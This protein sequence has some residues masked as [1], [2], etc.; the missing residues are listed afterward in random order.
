MGKGARN[1]ANRRANQQS[2]NGGALTPEALDGLLELRSASDLTALLSRRPGL[3]ADAVLEQLREM[4]RAEGYGAT[5]DQL[6][7]LLAGAREDHLV[8]WQH[9]KRARDRVD[10]LAAELE[11]DFLAIEHATEARRDDDVIRLARAAIPKANAA[12]AGLAASELHAIV[13]KA[14]LRS[15]KAHR[16]E[17]LEEAITSFDAALALTVDPEQA[18]NHLMHLGLVYAERIR[19]DRADNL[20]RA[21]DLLRAA[22]DQLGPDTAPETWAIMRTNLAV[23]LQRTERGNRVEVLEEAE[24]LCREALEY[25]SP[26]VDAVDW[27][28]TQLNLGEILEEL[29]AIGRRNITD[30]TNAYSGIVD[31]A[32]RIDE[33]WLI[34][35]AHYALGRLQSRA[36]EASPEEILDAHERDELAQLFDTGDLLES[37][38]AHLA[39]ACELLA[40][41]PDPI[42]HARAMDQLGGVLAALE[43]DDDAIAISREALGILRPT[44]A[45]SACTNVGMRLGGLLAERGQWS[46]AAA[47]YRDAFQAAELTFH[48]R[49][50][51]DARER[52]ARRTR[53]LARWA[54]FVVARS[55]D[56]VEAARILESG[57]AREL[58]R[59][60]GQHGPDTERLA[61]LPRSLR[62]AYDDAV[63][64]LVASPMGTT[65]A[66][67]SRILQ[68]VIAEIRRIPGYEDFGAVTDL[69]D[70]AI[71][72]EPGWPVVYVNPTPFGTLLLRISGTL[73]E[74]V[75]DPIF[76]DS[77]RSID[78]FMRLMIGDAADHPDDA[79]S[80]SSYLIGAGGA[81]DR[82]NGDLQID[83]EQI[84]PW[85]G[86]AIAKPVHDCIAA[87]G[88][89]GAT[90]IP[91]GPIGVAPIHAAM[92]R[93]GADYRC[94]LDRFS[95][96]FAPSSVLASAS[97]RRAASSQT[98]TPSLVALGDPTGDLPAAEPEVREIMRHFEGR[99]AVTFGREANRAF[100]RAHAG[101]AT[102]LHLA[103]HAS[104]ALFDPD[105]AGVLLS[106][107]AVSAHDLTAVLELSTRLV[108]ISA[109]QTALSEIAG[110]PDEAFS[111]GTTMLAAGSAC[112]IA[113]LWPVHDMATALL[114]A[115]LYDE[116]IVRSQRPPE[117]L[118]RAQLWLRDLT[119]E[120]EARFLLQ[121]PALADEFRERRAQNRRLPPIRATELWRAK[122]R[123]YSH[124]DYW[125][126]FVAVGA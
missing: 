19:D 78:V 98:A 81:G 36:S 23:A 97:L 33:K 96:R 12:G 52:E 22:F 13:G 74:P 38:R 88:A 87:V 121:H 41:G 105:E 126:G 112:A 73:D 70:L 84:M 8:A 50:D 20:G 35:A 10:A 53:G 102:H 122:G 114:M 69:G 72:L 40:T 92:W 29:A 18:A 66:H 80:A 115:R 77:P 34:G 26:A 123:P 89:T 32:A 46:E 65:G 62:S 119:N 68:E 55:G 48:G 90:L 67:T 45:P 63:R 27:A 7:A 101:D 25:R 104:G 79:P 64:S 103:C 95:I 82:D 21:I 107:G 118:G 124:P 9:F 125:A 4:A 28:H 51:N 94:L 2:P 24:G 37:A 42:R 99:A 113:S 47:A 31:E 54:A 71:A 39:T 86:E 116:L 3:L 17:D 75:I 93:E 5:F 1:R 117:A 43:H 14:L 110:L 120:G 56:P 109:C 76:L 49:L 44:S 58:R 15:A 60:L 85:I 83:L 11:Q 30:A 111:I 6:A 100:L 106:D 59:R 57:R 91:C 61:D 108:A 16:A